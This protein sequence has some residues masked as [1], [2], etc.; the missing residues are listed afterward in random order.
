MNYRKNL[1]SSAALLND[2]ERAEYN[3]DVL[4]PYLNIART[5][6][7]EVFALDNIPVTNKTSATIMVPAGTTEIGFETTPALPSDLVEIQELFESP[8]GQETWMSMTRKAF[9][10]D[11]NPGNA[12]LSYFLVWAW[13][14]QKIQ[15]LSAIVDID[16]KLDYIQSLF[17]T[18]TKKQL[19]TENSIINSDLYFQFRVA[20]LAAEYIMQ[21]TDRADRLNNNAMTALDRSLGISV[22][23]RQAIF[24]RR[25]PF[26]AAYKR[27]RVV[28]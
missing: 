19:E 17:S 25:R 2:T 1:A 8:T 18:I 12:E 27:R 6:L 24:T 3:D 13:K 14:D 28:G 9:L 21:D 20:G 26:R 23:G 15:V 16:I 11:Q 4:L 7:Q 22:K 10:T 5:E